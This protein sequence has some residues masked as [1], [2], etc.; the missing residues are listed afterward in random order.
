MG[1]MNGG[2]EER[3]KFKF[4]SIAY[5]LDVS[6]WLDITTGNP[7]HLGCRIDDRHAG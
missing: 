3:K 2:V 4:G 5:A 6:S 7:S 1:R